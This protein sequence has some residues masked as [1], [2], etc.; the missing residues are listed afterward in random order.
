M[1]VERCK[2]CETRRPFRARPVRRL[3]ESKEPLYAGPKTRVTWRVV[4]SPAS[5]PS[6]LGENPGCPRCLLFQIGSDPSE[7]GSGYDLLALK[8]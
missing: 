4:A 7:L 5:L 6:V 3:R 2:E 1:E 8:I